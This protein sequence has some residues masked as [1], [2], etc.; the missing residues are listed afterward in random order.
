MFK[1]TSLLPN[2]VFETNKKNKVFLEINEYDESLIK[3]L[4][5]VEDLMYKPDDVGYEPYEID[6]LVKD[7][8]DWTW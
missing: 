2:Y 4:F 5:T 7:K 6:L 1:K 3:D 8:P